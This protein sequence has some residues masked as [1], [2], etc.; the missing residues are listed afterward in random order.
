MQ[1]NLRMLPTSPRILDP[2][3]RGLL[4]TETSD[5]T[6]HFEWV[7]LRQAPRATL[8]IIQ[9]RLHFQETAFGRAQ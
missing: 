1:P 6:T 4:V 8:T 2:H 3:L 7:R 9:K 5:H